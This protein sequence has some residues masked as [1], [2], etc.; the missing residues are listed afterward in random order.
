[1]TVCRCQRVGL[2]Q[3]CLSCPSPIPILSDSQDDE[4]HLRNKPDGAN[5][6]S[7]L[8]S[9]G[10]GEKIIDIYEE[11]LNRMSQLLLKRALKLWIKAVKHSQFPFNGGKR[12]REAIRKRGPAKPQWWPNDVTHAEPDHLR[13]PG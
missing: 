2:I 5:P 8:V 13:K 6:Y 7:G 12:R 10:D 11:R 1:M 4:R 3:S 9:V